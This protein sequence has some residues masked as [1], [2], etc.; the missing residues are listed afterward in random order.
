[1]E[2][3]EKKPFYKQKKFWAGMLTL[4]AGVLSG[5]VTWYDAIAQA[6]TTAFGG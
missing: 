4:G 2:T 6:I 1:M 3:N 5:A